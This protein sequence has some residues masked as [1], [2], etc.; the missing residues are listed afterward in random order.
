MFRVAPVISE[1]SLQEESE[2]HERAY[3]NDHIYI[4]SNPE[5][6]KLMAGALFCIFYFKK[7]SQNVNLEKNK[8]VFNIFESFSSNDN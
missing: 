6:W 7:K 1:D 8:N 5:V 4:W 2:I 3:S